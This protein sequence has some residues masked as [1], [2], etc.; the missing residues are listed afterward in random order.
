MAGRNALGGFL[1]S[2]FAVLM[3][4]E[5][6][7]LAGSVYAAAWLRFPDSEEMVRSLGAIWP[8]A[9]VYMVVMLLA[10]TAVGLYQKHQRE[11]MAGVVLRLLVA[12]VSGSVVLVLIF[13]LF[14]GL[15]LGRGVFALAGLISFFVIG[16]VR[17]VFYQSA[18]E[19][20][21]K[22]RVLVLGCGERAASIPRN[23]RRKADRRGFEIVGFVSMPGHHNAVPADQIIHLEGAS[24]AEYACTHDIDEIVVAMDDRRKSF[25]FDDLLEC[26]LRGVEVLDLPHFF[27]REAGKVKLDLLSPSFI[28]FSEGFGRGTLRNALERVFDVVV[29][30]VLLILAA[31]VMLLT[32]A[33]ILWEC[34]SL[35]CPVLYRQERVGLDGKT[36]EVLKFRSMRT[37]AEKDGKAVWA[38]KDDPR[39]TKV[40]RFIRKTRIDELPQIFNVLRGE[41][42]F[43][44]PRP[45]RP[46]FVQELGRKLPYYHE[47]HR[48]KPGV[49]GWAQLNY[50]YGSSDRDAME[51]LQYDLYYVKNHSLLLDLLIILQTVEVVLFGKGAR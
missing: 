40:G 14:P 41:M 16:T 35:K 26:K 13:Y 1:R 43:V 15:Y 19:S 45:E 32:A 48:V 8:K 24:L 6:L 37:D 3:G 20:A 42:S 49:T 38:T 28:I 23:L 27:E 11:R 50:P 46:Q 21:F 18:D 34:R 25:P 5:A 31:P 44:G 36:F 30:L 9:L 47:R 22:R 7:I 2:P 29:S 12:L 33:A 17:P 4:I 51:K 10:M 39:V